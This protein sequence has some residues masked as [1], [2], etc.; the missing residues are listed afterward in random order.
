VHNEAVLALIQ[1]YGEAER[2]AGHMEEIGT[3]NRAFHIKAAELFDEI[4]QLLALQP[5]N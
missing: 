5:K 3:G 4:E 2:M 1:Q